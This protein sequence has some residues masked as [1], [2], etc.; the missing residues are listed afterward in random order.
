M[1]H[2]VEKACYYIYMKLVRSCPIITCNAS[3]ETINFIACE[4]RKIRVKTG[5][6]M[7]K[8]YFL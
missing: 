1:V 7:K 4:L 2:F 3:F 8:R 5:K 6:V